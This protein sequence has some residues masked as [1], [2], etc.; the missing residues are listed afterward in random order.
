MLF[1]WWFQ[2]VFL[3]STLESLGVDSNWGT[4]LVGLT[5]PD[6]DAACFNA[7]A[8]PVRHIFS[9]CGYGCEMWMINVYPSVSILFHHVPSCSIILHHYPSFSPCSNG[10]GSIPV[11]TI[12]RGMN[13]HLPAILMFT[14]GIGF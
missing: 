14:R 1:G 8:R 11:H 12:F 7:A 5:L 2:R 4:T 10:Y 13:I 9:T 6:V 3:F